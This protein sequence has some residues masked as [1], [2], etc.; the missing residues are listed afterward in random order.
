VDATVVEVR[1]A[2]PCAALRPFVAG[3]RGYRLRGA[4]GTHRGLPSRHLTFIVSI[5]DPVE[6][7]RMPQG[8]QEPGAFRAFVGGLHTSP[9]LIRHDGVQHGV[10]LS[11]TPLGA[12]AVLGVPAGV[13]GG[14]VV[15]LD[16]LLGRLGVELVDRLASASGW[17]E[18][19]AVLDDVLV[20]RLVAD[21]DPPPM[22]AA[23]WR[24][25]VAAGGGLEVR[26][27]AAELGMSRRHLGEL[28]R[29]EVGLSPKAAAR[30]LRFERARRLLAWPA[31]PGLAEVAL[32]SGYCDQSHLTREWREM[33]GCT[34]TTWIAEELP[35][36][37]ELPS[38][39]DGSPEAV[40]P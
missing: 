12:R 33:A 15:A 25:L 22:V 20:R 9:A 16:D 36:V 17:P 23:A 34:P 38:V 5:A 6:I 13:L 18:R 8:R 1:T 21:R 3:Y 40:S 27:L 24:R 37:G 28:F 30:V 19:F 4:P 10:S 11:L 7:A 31:R 26:A 2:P 35:S 32:A 14:S 29:R 39:Q